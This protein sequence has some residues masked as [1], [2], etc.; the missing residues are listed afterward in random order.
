LFGLNPL[1]KRDAAA[2]PLT[3]L[4]TL[5]APRKD[6]P[7][8]LRAVASPDAATSAEAMADP[9]VPISVCRPDNSA[10]EGNLPGIIQAALGQDLA[11]SPPTERPAVIARVCSIK[12]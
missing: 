1:T 9:A 2:N 8:V 5:A 7:E 6:A 10:D 12:K 3:S 11:V 4:L